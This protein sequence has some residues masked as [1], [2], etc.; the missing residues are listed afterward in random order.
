MFRNSNGQR[1]RAGE[2]EQMFFKHRE[3]V[4]NARPDLIS[5]SEEI[6]DQYG[7]SRSFHRGSTS[8][9]DNQGQPPD[10]IDTNN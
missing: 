2:L 6:D 3:Q 8:E 9:A 5:S 4:Q 10:V 1:I 7:I